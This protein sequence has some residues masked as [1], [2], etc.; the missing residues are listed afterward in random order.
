MK[1]RL[2]VLLTIVLTTLSLKSYAQDPC[3]ER[4]TVRES[5]TVCQGDRTVTWRNGIVLTEGRTEIIYDTFAPVDRV[6]DSIVVYEGSLDVHPL[7]DVQISGR[8]SICEGETTTLTVE[9]DY[10]LR[11]RGPVV[12]GAITPSIT[13]ARSGMY[14]ITAVDRYMCMASDTIVVVVSPTPVF[15]TT[16]SRCEDNPFDLHGTLCDSTGDYSVTLQTVDHCDSTINVH[17]TVNP[18][19]DLQFSGIIP[20]CEGTSMC[21]TASGG[22]RYEWS[23]GADSN[24]A[25]ITEGGIYH[26]TAWTDAGCQ[27]SDTLD[28]AAYPSYAEHYYDGI[29]FG[30]VYHFYEFD[31]TRAGDYTHREVSENG[32]DSLFIMHLVLKENATYEYT[33]HANDSFYWSGIWYNRSGDFTQRNRGSNGCDS[34]TTLH[35]ELTFGRPVPRILMLNERV[36]MVNKTVDYEGGEWDG[37]TW[38]QWYRNG[39][40]IRHAT[41]DYYHEEN[42]G[43]LSG[44]YYVRVAANAE[45]TEWMSSDTICVNWVG[46]EAAEGEEIAVWPNP[47]ERGGTVTAGIAG[48]KKLSLID[49]N[50]REVGESHDNGLTTSPHLPRGPYVLKIE[51]NN[52]KQYHKQ[53]VVR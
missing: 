30:D 25:C 44:C 16:F 4:D 9:G 7:P 5:F 6:C 26:V 51:M 21:I 3:Y 12:N 32:C 2:I 36:L 8:D 52:G 11:W 42:Y 37:Y 17:L 33:I 53:I 43:L 47:V 39:N 15:D 20:F 14:I 22:D 34:I 23:T 10:T 18:L 1:T 49:M 29:C 31:L 48:V 41:Q 46:I 35:L 50:G 27:K 38:Y 28:I 45:G 40:M 24:V 19:P 13:V